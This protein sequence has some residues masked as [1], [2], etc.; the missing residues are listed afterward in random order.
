MAGCLIDVL[1]CTSGD[2]SALVAQGKDHLDLLL[3][4]LSNVR[5]KQSRYLSSLMKRADHGIGFELPILPFHL[6][7]D[8]MSFFPVTYSQ[9]Q[10]LSPVSPPTQPAN[11][12]P[13]LSAN[14]R[15]EISELPMDSDVVQP[16][17]GGQIISETHS[18]WL[19]LSRA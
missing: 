7:S 18:S 10:L 19:P 16:E 9:R 5:G 4:R 12:L 1:R 15:L 6:Q 13:S 2:P 17:C 8:S 11:M 14:G 3:K